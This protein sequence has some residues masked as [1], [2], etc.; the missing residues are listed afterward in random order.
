MP[1]RTW[2]FISS[3]ETTTL[4]RVLRISE[5]WVGLMATA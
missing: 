3:G 2:R 4:G 1:G 5:L